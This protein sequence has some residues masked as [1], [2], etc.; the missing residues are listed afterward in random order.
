MSGLIQPYLKVAG[1]INDDWGRLCN[2]KLYV[3]EKEHLS[4][5]IQSLK[6]ILLSTATVKLLSHDH[7]LLQT[8]GV[9]K[10]KAGLILPEQEVGFGNSSGAQSK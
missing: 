9:M 7:R 5:F 4:Y 2:V 3:N 6:C 10:S 8:S 1:L